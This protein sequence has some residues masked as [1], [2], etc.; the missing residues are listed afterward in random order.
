MKKTIAL[1]VI[2]GMIFIAGCTDTYPQ[3]LQ[4]YS[5]DTAVIQYEL[6][7]NAEG[8]ETLYIRGDQ[9]ALH[10]FV[11]RADTEENTF[12]LDLGEEMYIADLQKMTAVKANNKDYEKLKSMTRE[13]QEEYLIKK[14]LGLKN[15][16]DLGE[17]LSQKM[18]AGKKCDVYQV[19]NIGT[20]C[21][22]DG[23]VLEKEMQILDKTSKKVAVSVETNV[24]I[25]NER[26]ELP[27][28]VIKTNE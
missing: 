17:P 22:W 11:T 26:F 12:E 1:C 7:G 3:D 15:N 16:V 6:S 2:T 5:F 9:R 28:G 14:E 27:E 19:P 10:R 23:I 8:E 25:P 4:V 24:E 21:V 13:E 18:V 20:A